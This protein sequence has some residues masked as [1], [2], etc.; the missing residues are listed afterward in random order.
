MRWLSPL[1]KKDVWICVLLLAISF[2]IFSQGLSQHGLE[3]RDD[4]IFYFKSTQEM[5]LNQNYL[6]PTYFGENRFQKPILYYWFVLM[7]YKIF[8]VNWVGARFVAVLFAGFTVCLTWLLARDLFHDRRLASLS[9]VILLTTVLFVR[10]AKNA[11]PDMPLNFFIVLAMYA[12]NRLKS[13]WGA[14][15]EFDGQAGLH[16]TFQG[17]VASYRWVFIWACAL[18][19]MVKGFAAL[20]FPVGVALLYCVLARDGV[21]LKRLRLGRGMV[22]VCCICAPWFL[23]MIYAHGSGYLEYMLVDETKNRLLGA[24]TTDHYV[25]MKLQAFAQHA[26]FYLQVL[27]ALF[28]PWSVFALVAI[29]WAVFRFFRREDPQ[30]LGFLLLWFF[31]VYIFFSLMYFTISHYMLVLST[32]LA[33]L[34]AYFFQTVEA[35]AWM[36]RLNKGLVIFLLTVGA[37]AYAVLCVFLAGKSLICLPL[38]GILYGLMVWIVG[39]TQRAYMAPMMLGVFLILV[40]TQSRLL[41]EAGVTSQSILQRFA[42]TIHQNQ[43]SSMIVGIGSR[44]IHEKEFQVYFTRRVL[45]PTFGYEP[46]HKKRLK[47]FL[48]QPRN[49]YCLMSQR[50]I[51]HFIPERIHQFEVIQEEYMM[52]RRMSI[53]GGFFKALLKLD[54]STIHDYLMEKVVLFKKEQKVGLDV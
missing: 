49:F 3:Y 10:H 19:F 53:D 12:I 28:A 30:S 4:E 32:P 43:D 54:Q 46:E 36:R 23:Y 37:V 17:A 8:G 22:L 50:D 18:G 29:P 27:G 34:I 39:R 52:R 41:G 15:K 33:I 7:S 40:L 42:R 44:D 48:D 35:K 25:W 2:L 6:S 51:Q 24:A 11:V 45:K 9:A 38:V 31:G 14:L 16:E 13:S 26:V 20:I 21:L 5:L 47:A 1:F